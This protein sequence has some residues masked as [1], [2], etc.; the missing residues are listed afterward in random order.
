MQYAAISD[1]SQNPQ[2]SAAAWIL[3]SLLF[4]SLTAN[5]NGLSASADGPS[6]KVQAQADPN[7]FVRDVL[8]NEIQAEGNDH[9]LWT[10]Q[11]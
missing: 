9:S 10:Y 5:G 11:G 1:S 4:L 7:T 3:S 2:L 6:P 8:Q